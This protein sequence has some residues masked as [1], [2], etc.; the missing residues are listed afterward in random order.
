ME[1]NDDAH[2]H[3]RR[4][5]K[6]IAAALKE[7][8]EGK[9]LPFAIIE[10]ATGKAVGSTRYGSIDTTNRK[11]EIGWTWVARRWQRNAVNT[12]TKYLLLV[13]AF[14]TLGCIRVEFKTDYTNKQSRNALLRIGAKKEGILRN[15]MIAPGGRIRH[16]VY[17]SIID[18]GW[19]EVKARLEKKLMRT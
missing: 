5:E 2:S 9:S 11:V 16:S 17:Y 18:S 4:N 7:Q 13:H 14:E 1:S 3:A 19:K 10:K 6:Y 12:E 15:H 8:T